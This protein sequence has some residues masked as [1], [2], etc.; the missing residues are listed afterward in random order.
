MALY[1]VRFGYSS[2]TWAALVQNPQ[3]RREL[4]QS[5]MFAFGGR[6]HG[7]WYSLG[8][9]DGYALTEFPDDVSVAAAHVAIE[10]SGAFDHLDAVQLL[11]VEEMM[12]AM[13]RAGDVVYAKPGG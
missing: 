6:L 8:E 2:E 5:R 12:V 10:A 9:H 11:T 1:L 4:L 3:D 13:D 7:F